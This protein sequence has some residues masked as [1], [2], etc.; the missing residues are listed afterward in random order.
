MAKFLI[1]SDPKLSPLVIE[2]V[3][4]LI[5]DDKLCVHAVNATADGA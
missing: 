1:G 4:E 5:P 2:F 3:P